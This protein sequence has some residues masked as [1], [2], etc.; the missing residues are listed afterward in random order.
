MRFLCKRDLLSPPAPPHVPP[1]RKQRTPITPYIAVLRCSNPAPSTHI[2]FEFAPPLAP[3]SS[4]THSYASGLFVG[5]NVVFY[6]S[7]PGSVSCRPHPWQRV[8][9]ALLWQQSYTDLSWQLIV[10][11]PHWASGPRDTPFGRSC[12]HNTEQRLYIYHPGQGGGK[13]SIPSPGGC[14]NLYRVHLYRQQTPMAGLSHTSDNGHI[15]TGSLLISVRPLSTSVSNIF[16][17]PR[18][19]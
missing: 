16:F 8:T 18:I 13:Q 10:N 1:I 15:Y 11:K 14:Y 19:A 6:S 7:L 9:R 3:R 5:G 4:W 17:K 2:L 12:T